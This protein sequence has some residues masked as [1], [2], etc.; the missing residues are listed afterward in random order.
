MKK[1]LIVTALAG[2]FRSFLT[3]DILLLQSMGY[4]V[5]CAAN[6]SHPGSEGMIEYFDNHNIVFHNISFSSYKPLSK[7]TIKATKELK[8]LL[9]NYSF[10]VVHCHTPIAGAITRWLCRK[11]R[12][13]GLK[14]IYTT[15][16]FY[17]HKYSSKKAWIIFGTIEKIMSRFCD[18]IITINNEDYHNAIKMHCDKVFHINGVGVDTKRFHIKEFDRN[19]YRQKLG[20]PENALVILAVGELSERKNQKIIIEALGKLH[21]PD[22]LFVHCGNAM[23]KASTKDLLV[24]LA[25]ELDVNF[26]M[27]GL[28]K[29]IPQI[30]QCADIGTISSKREGL[31]LAGIEMLASGLP[32]VA[33]RVHGILDY[34][35]DGIN[36]YLADPN[37][38]DEFALGISKLVDKNKRASMREACIKSAEP[39]DIECSYK[40]M[41]DI[42]TELL[43]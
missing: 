16:G 42:Y 22:V 13:K 31:G 12:K 39:F 23:N 29:D 4:E 33:S 14:V 21:L 17:F 20:I 37:N 10:D 11:Q 6:I 2:F 36:G 7:E 43:G 30:C 26:M 19:E 24:E 27:L 18:A 25:D 34:M 3:H 41:R 15:H 9:Q 38:A 5:H 8:L 40:Q 28:R 32:L 1:V 35:E